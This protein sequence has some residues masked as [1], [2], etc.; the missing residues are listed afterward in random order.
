MIYDKSNKNEEDCQCL[1][2]LTTKNEHTNLWDI[3]NYLSFMLYPFA[4]LT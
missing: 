1:S 2:L 3:I 4:S